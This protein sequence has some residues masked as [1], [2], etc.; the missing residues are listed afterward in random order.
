VFFNNGNKYGSIPIG[1]STTMKEEYKVIS[2]ALEK[3]HYQE[4]QWVI[5]VDLKM[6]NFLLGQQSGYTNILPFYALGRVEPNLST[7]QKKIG[8]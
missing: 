4:H 5:C 8:H 6:V 7:G 3:I 1:Q 2:L